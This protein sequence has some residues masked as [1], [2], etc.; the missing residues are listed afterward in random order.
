M[1]RRTFYT[2]AL[3]QIVTRV[4]LIPRFVICGAVLA[5]LVL[6]GRGVM[7]SNPSQ[8]HSQSLPRQHILPL[9][10]RSVP[11]LLAQARAHDPLLRLPHARWF[12]RV[13]HGQARLIVVD[14]ASSGSD[15]GTR[16]CQ[17]LPAP[18]KHHRLDAT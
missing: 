13:Q 16:S 14:H 15:Q 5:A 4:R 2:T 1:K 7:W 10:Y 3:R 11:A 18:A 8:H 9:P 17:G 6:V 12:I